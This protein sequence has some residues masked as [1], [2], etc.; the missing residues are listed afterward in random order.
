MPSDPRLPPAGGG[1]VETK[2][3]PETILQYVPTK[4]GR[5]NKYT[6]KTKT[7]QKMTE[8]SQNFLMPLRNFLD[9]I[10]IN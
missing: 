9:K 4:S 8:A 1:G 5:M 2:P 7:K 10:K 3:K 6:K